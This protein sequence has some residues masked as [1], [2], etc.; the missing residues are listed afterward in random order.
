MASRDKAAESGEKRRERAITMRRGQ[1]KEPEPEPEMKPDPAPEMKPEPVPVPLEPAQEEPAHAEMS[2]DQ[3]VSAGL[4]SQDIVAATLSAMD[5]FDSFVGQDKDALQKQKDAAENVALQNDEND[6]EAREV[7]EAFDDMIALKILTQGDIDRLVHEVVTGTK[8][9]VRNARRLL[10]DHDMDVNAAVSYYIS[11]LGE[12]ALLTT[13]AGGLVTHAAMAHAAMEREARRNR[14]KPAPDKQ[15]CM[16]AAKGDV[17][18]MTALLDAGVSASA[19]DPIGGYPALH[20]AA[21]YNRVSAVQL[22]LRRGVDIEAKDDW[23][24]MTAYTWG[25]VCGSGDAVDCLLRAGCRMEAQDVIGRTGEHFARVRQHESVKQAIAIEF[26]TRN[27]KRQQ[28]HYSTM[29]R[30]P[31][32]YP[33]IRDPNIHAPTAAEEEKQRE[34]DQVAAALATMLATAGPLGT[35]RDRAKA[36]G[37][38]H[39][40]E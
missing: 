19:R 27:H 28:R 7:K 3:M 37:M 31:D 5:S 30:Q 40:L 15:L 14:E 10:L 6:A 25:S 20:Y 8:C 32:V 23:G 9:G 26:S 11:K 33:A 38:E 16:C 2:V 34:R 4:S 18:T 24:Q 36:A 39:T 13:A 1:P 21:E 17:K 35:V 12:G 22:L 29:V